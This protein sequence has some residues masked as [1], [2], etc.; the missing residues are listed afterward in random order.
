[1]KNNRALLVLLMVL[2]MTGDLIH[3]FEQCRQ[4]SYRLCSTISLLN[5]TP[6]DQEKAILEELCR[7]GISHNKKGPNFQGQLAVINI[8]T[9]AL[10]DEVKW[11]GGQCQNVVCQ[12]DWFLDE[13]VPLR[14]GW[15][16]TGQGAYHWYLNGL[17]LWPLLNQVLSHRRRRFLRIMF[18]C[19]LDWP[20]YALAMPAYQIQNECQQMRDPKIA[21]MK[22]FK[23][24]LSGA[25]FSKALKFERFVGTFMETF[26]DPSG[27][28][29]GEKIKNLEDYDKWLK[30]L[31][32][33]SLRK[34]LKSHAKNCQ[35][36]LYIFLL[37]KPRDNFISE[38]MSD[39]DVI[40]EEIKCQVP[41]IVGFRG[42][43]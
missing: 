9:N 2:G 7:A 25:E 11:L 37:I 30:H 31:V 35:A 6:N 26:K 16:G 22:L 27:S 23:Q 20:N 4:T 3:S 8:H 5:G 43:Q 39:L 29:C 38:L 33:S 13:T 19:K 17:P 28:F 42:Y 18:P 10:S 15:K 34:M 36:K 14:P 24:E 21:V 41:I 12:G 40:L 32:R 1:M